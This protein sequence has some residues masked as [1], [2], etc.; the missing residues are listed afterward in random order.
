MKVAGLGQCSLDYIILLEKFPEEDRKEEAR[1]IVVQGG[2]PVATALVALSRLG[3]KA[4]FMGIVSDDRAGVEIKK[5]LAGEGIDIRGLKT[6]RGGSSQVAAII[7]NS[8]TG[9]RTILWKRNT[10]GPLKPA[11][12]KED[13][14][15]GKDFLLI[16]G[17]MAEASLKAARLARK[18][19]M[20]VMLDAGRVRHG[21]LKL[22]S[23][24]DYIVASEEFAKDFA[25]TPKGALLKLSKFNPKA[26]TITLGKKGSITWAGGKTFSTPA[27]KVEAKDTTG[28]GDVFHGAYVFGILKGWELRKVL[29]FASIVAAL[30]CLKPG[31]RAGIPGY[32]EA[33]KA[34]K[35]S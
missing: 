14:L 23:L 16:D 21:M 12:V 33:M 20:P 27:Y 10:T 34:F 13:F 7:V 29:E 28:A 18:M 4:S 32:R 26:A 6:K 11:E 19:G 3:A 31:G 5:G 9:S 22:A 15:K 25:K 24:S 1:E 17:L 30:K 2:G 8:R 35:S